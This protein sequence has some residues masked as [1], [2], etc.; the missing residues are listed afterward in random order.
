MLA[1]LRPR[2]LDLTTPPEQL[3]GCATLQLQTTAVCILQST[4]CA[5]SLPARDK[6]RTR[7]LSDD[8]T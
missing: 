6:P 1:P 5:C 4:L 8:S 2:L 3:R 7:A